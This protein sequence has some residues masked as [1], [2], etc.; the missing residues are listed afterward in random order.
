MTDG[1]VVFITMVIV[2]VPFSDRV[3]GPLPNGRTSWL[4]N[5]GDPN[6]ILTGM[7]LQVDYF[8]MGI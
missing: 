6:H 5:A 1:Y 8:F 7:I 4:I 2:F 3:V